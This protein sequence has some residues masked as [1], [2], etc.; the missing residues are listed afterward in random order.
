MSRGALRRLFAGT[1]TL[2][3]LGSLVACI[4][5]C[6]QERVVR[7]RGGLYGMPGSETGLG[8]GVAVGPA[9]G[10][11]LESVVD[12]YYGGRSQLSIGEPIEGRPNRRQLEDGSVFLV[13][14]SPADLIRHLFD[15][16]VD[17]EWDLLYD[18]L[19]SE[20]TK[21]NYRQSDRDPIDAARFIREH[22]ADFVAL[23]RVLGTGQN[24][25]GVEFRSLGGNV[26][27]M[28]VL[29]ARDFGQKFDRMDVKIEDGRFVLLMVS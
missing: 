8:E 17:S 11:T 23:L 28:R 27:R 10:T 26:F 20:E 9:R 22:R 13:S 14:R 7:V 6:A 21:D 3:V 4:A 25:P 15:T 16:V 24:S 18:Q 1:A 29:D 12:E 2:S 5:G 19:I